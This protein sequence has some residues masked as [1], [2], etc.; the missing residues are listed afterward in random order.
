[1]GPP[2]QHTHDHVAEHMAVLCFPKDSQHDGVGNDQAEKQ[3][4]DE[5]ENRIHRE[6][7][8]A[9][10]LGYPAGEGGRQEIGRIFDEIFGAAAFESIAVQNKR[11][12]PEKR[13]DRG[14]CGSNEYALQAQRRRQ[15]NRDDHIDNCRHHGDIFSF[16]EHTHGIPESDIHL[17]H[18]C[19]IEIQHD[20]KDDRQ[21]QKPFRADPQL[22]EW[23]K[24]HPE[25][26]RAESKEPEIPEINRVIHII[27][28][29][30]R[31]F[32]IQIAD[33]GC[34]RMEHLLQQI[35]NRCRQKQIVGVNTALHN[36]NHSG[37]D[38]IIR[39]VDNH[40]PGTIEHQC[41][42]IA[43]NSP[44]FPPAQRFVITLFDIG[45]HLVGDEHGDDILQNIRPHLDGKR[46]DI[47][48]RQQHDH[49]LH[50]IAENGCGIHHISHDI[51]FLVSRDQ[52]PFIGKEVS[53]CRIGHKE[54]EDH[55]QIRNIL[56]GLHQIPYKRR[57]RQTHAD[58]DHADGA[59]RPPIHVHQRLDFVGVVLGHWL[60]HGVDNRRP[61]AQVRQREHHED[62]GKQSVYAQVYLPQGVDKHRPHGKAHEDIQN[63]SAQ[64]ERNI[65]HGI[66]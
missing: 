38:D 44:F 5:G 36:A 33:T 41:P 10:Q 30:V 46:Q 32:H 8:V 22:N 47:V 20:P 14:N 37:N 12:Q 1:M 63:L 23:V 28:R 19:H 62:V 21:A 15:P 55:L 34:N 52:R 64:G 7:R 27:F 6:H 35:F 3:P 51:I 65:S 48:M 50:A 31:L 56:V 60:V 9:G 53:R 16:P 4:A 57:H 61:H 59:V 26:D 40:L 58:D 17:P 49:N 66:P 2:F 25:A 43:V 24:Q 42:H 13:G 29:L 45:I 11:L 18:A 39:P 54:Q